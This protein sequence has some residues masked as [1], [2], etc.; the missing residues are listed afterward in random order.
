MVGPAKIFPNLSSFNIS[1]S[2]SSSCISA[3]GGRGRGFGCTV[4]S[5]FELDGVCLGLT[6]LAE[7][8]QEL[9]YGDGDVGGGVGDDG[10]HGDGGH[11]DDG[12]HGNDGGHGDD[13]NDDG[14]VMMMV[15]MVLAMIMVVPTM[16]ILGMKVWYHDRTVTINLP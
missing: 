9:L 10:G 14:C 4:C 2:C 11:G 7:N 6:S 16:I 8:M 12:G 15:K 1:C 13:S 5:L 3:C